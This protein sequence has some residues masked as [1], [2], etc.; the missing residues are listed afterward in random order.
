MSS[1]IS[2]RE[3]ESFSE[4]AERLWEVRRARESRPP[5]K[6]AAPAPAPR[7]N[8]SGIKDRPATDTRQRILRWIEEGTKWMEEGRSLLRM[9]DGVPDD[10]E[11]R[12]GTVE[13]SEQA[14]AQRQREGRGLQPARPSIVELAPTGD[15]DMV[16]AASMKLQEYLDGGETRFIL[17]LAEVTYMD[18][19]GLG[20]VVRAMKRARQAGGDVK[21]CALQGEILRIFEVTGLNKAIAVYP[22]LEDA[23][24]SW[25]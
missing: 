4:W 22:T 13:A 14:P 19:G 6:P 8:G 16:S 7:A 3:G 20:E 2:L 5:A 24:A 17:D 18:S 10:N 1:D 25:L 9:L 23:R 11:R 21:V 12:R 15:L